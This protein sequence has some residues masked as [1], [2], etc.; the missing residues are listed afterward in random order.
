V[1][2]PTPQQ[3]GMPRKYRDWRPDQPVAIQDA[4]DC[5][6]RVVVQ[7]QGTGKGKTAGYV[8]MALIDKDRRYGILTATKGLQDQINDE[9]GGI[10]IA[11]IRGKSAYS[12][13]G[14]P[15]HTCAEGSIAKCLY[16]GSSLCSHH[17]AKQE[18]LQSRIF[19][20][21]YS[22]W[23]ATN[24]YSQGFGKIDVLVCDEAH[25][26]PGEIEKAMSVLL[27][28]HEIVDEL[29]RDWPEYNSRNDMAVWKHWALVTRSI[30]DRELQRIKAEVDKSGK[31][32]AAKLAK[33]FNHYQNLVRRLAEIATCKADRWVVDEWQHGYKFDAIDPSEYAER[34]L[35]RGVEKIVLVSGTITPKTLEQSGVDVHDAKFFEYYNEPRPERTPIIYVP[36]TKVNVYSQPW[37][38]RKMVARVDEIIES[39]LDRKGIVHTSSYKIRDFIVNNS[40]Y[41]RFMVSNYVNNGE[42][43]SQVI[44]RFK[45]MSEPAVLVSPSV[46]TGYDFPYDLCRYQIVAKLNYPYAGSKVEQARTKLDPDRGSYHA[47][48]N[49]QQAVGRGDRADDD[50]QEVFIIDDAFPTLMWRYSELFSPV[51]AAC[52]KTLK[53][54][55]PAMTVKGAA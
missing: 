40:R 38:L 35:W 48:L 5:C 7:K 16:K 39:R 33:Q 45:R 42:L 47:I 51:F 10:G 13:D 11:D 23:I 31:S 30:A 4:L 29:K 41:A 24:K 3:L 28:E 55:P 2:F 8:G 36:T 12:C 54:V 20:T 18:A 44:E 52:V 46:T 37:Q 27:G 1:F 49:L 14:M 26:I 21:N 32:L 25:N 53:E 34:L 6:K 50:Y 43:T 19:A 9:F 22:C 15:G 17:A